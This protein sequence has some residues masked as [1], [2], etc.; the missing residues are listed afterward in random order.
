MG[1]KP[2]AVKYDTMKQQTEND[3]NA[4]T[5]TIQFYI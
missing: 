1:P 2:Y 5:N 4:H 3:R